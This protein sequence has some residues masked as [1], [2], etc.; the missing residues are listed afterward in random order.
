[1]THTSTPV[2][3]T[4][5]VDYFRALSIL[6]HRLQLF[7]SLYSIHIGLAWSFLLYLLISYWPINTLAAR[8]G[9]GAQAIWA[10]TIL[11][12]FFPT[13]KLFLYQTQD[14]LPRRHRKVFYLK[15]PQR[16][17]IHFIADTGI[18]IAL[19][20]IAFLA[21]KDWSIITQGTPIPITIF[22]AITLQATLWIL[23][24]GVLVPYVISESERN[25][26]LYRKIRQRERSNVALSN[27]P[28]QHTTDSRDS[29]SR[30]GFSHNLIRK[31][32]NARPFTINGLP[33]EFILSITLITQATLDDFSG[34]HESLPRAKERLGYLLEKI[35]QCENGSIR[36][37]AYDQYRA[38]VPRFAHLKNDTFNDATLLVHALLT[39][40]NLKDLKIEDIRNTIQQ[41]QDLADPWQKTFQRI[42][43]HGS[44]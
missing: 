15:E 31:I 40:T 22:L 32:E 36:S 14:K 42:L 28:R 39:A 26:K 38:E 18:G 29:L 2:S 35:M 44:S 23:T 33:T 19:L 20:L 13:I 6:P 12:S 37:D 16:V 8:L 21:I 25:S 11:P 43:S 1:M 9:L 4:Y 34:R 5:F 24:Q 10:T 7:L 30:Y 3:T 41:T 27:K 17:S